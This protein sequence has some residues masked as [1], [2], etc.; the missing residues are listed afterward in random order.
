[1]IDRPSVTFYGTYLSES[2]GS[3]IASETIA[4]ALR[5]RG[6]KVAMV[7]R[8]RTAFGRFVDA[9]IHALTERSDV[10]V[11]DVFSSR[12][13]YLTA[14]VAR[15]VFHRRVPIIA[16][17]Q[18]GALLE[19]YDEIKNPVTTILRRASRILSPSGFLTD[20]FSDKGFDVE[21]IPNAIELER[22]PYRERHRPRG[23]LR[24]LW[25]RAFTAI[26]RPTWPIEVV[27][28]LK[29]RGLDCRLTMIG[30]DKGMLGA[31]WAKA[32]D[33]DVTE[34]VEFTGPVPN[35]ELH[36][37]YHAHDFLLNTTEFESFG[38]ALI[39]AA[40]TGLPIVSAAVGEVRH[41]WQDEENIFLVPG[42]S[43]EEFSDR[44]AELQESDV[45]GAR[46]CHVSRTARDKVAEYALENVVPRWQHI[47]DSLSDGR[48]R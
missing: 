28:Q 27:S 7:S 41:G 9:L 20:A 13:V 36:R 46:Y 22:F 4:T 30:P 14:L 31:A 1:M 25:V 19:R 26:Y 42:E 35:N 10:V 5:L 18:G 6:F 16:I 48:P 12:V 44:I 38:V 29:R 23:A 39:E 8:K 43:S 21:N 11:L 2:L 33:L 34:E 3:I 45:S 24:L 15:V 37:Y 17:L 32:V 47:I 40:A